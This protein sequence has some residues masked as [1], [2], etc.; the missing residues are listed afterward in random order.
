M[1]MKNT[2]GIHK[3]MWKPKSEL[4]SPDSYLWGSTGNASYAPSHKGANAFHPKLF[5]IQLTLPAD[6]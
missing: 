5:V 4:N 3:S 6:K 2:S 1:I